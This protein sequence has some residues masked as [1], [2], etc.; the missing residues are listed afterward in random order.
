MP[1]LTRWSAVL[2]SLLAFSAAGVAPSAFAQGAGDEQYQDPFEDSSG[3]GT[4]TTPAPAKPSEPSSGSQGS[5]AAPVPATPSVAP[6]QAP[7]T[8]L[9]RTGSDLRVPLVVGVL[10]LSGG[11]LLFRLARP[12]STDR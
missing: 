10:L 11:A 8:E 6:T 1:T 2:F 4:E 12:A 7:A 9:A 3:G 5:G